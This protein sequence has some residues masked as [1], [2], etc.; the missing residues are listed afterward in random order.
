MYKSKNSHLREVRSMN[1]ST[2]EEKG[3]SSKKIQEYIEVL[4]TIICPHI[5]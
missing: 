1:Y 5:I 2:P 3:I 4:E